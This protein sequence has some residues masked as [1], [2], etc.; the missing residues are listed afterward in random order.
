MLYQPVQIN[1]SK[2]FLKMF[3]LIEFTTSLGNFG[4]DWGAHV[5]KKNCAGY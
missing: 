1:W 3:K 5:C 4:L 2:S